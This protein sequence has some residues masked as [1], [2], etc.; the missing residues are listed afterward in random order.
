MATRFAGSRSLDERRRRRLASEFVDVAPTSPVHDDGPGDASTPIAPIVHTDEFVAPFPLE[1]VIPRAWWMH[2]VIALL[3]IS[4]GGLTIVAGWNAGPIREACGPAIGNLV[5]FETGKLVLLFSAASLFFA[6][7]LALS[8]W[9]VRSRSASDFSGRYRIWVWAAVFAFGASLVVVGDLH[10]V[11]TATLMWN[12]PMGFWQQETLLWLAPAVGIASALIWEI[13]NELRDCRTSFGVFLLAILA[14]AASISLQ[15]GDGLELPQ[16]VAATVIAGAAMLGHFALMMSLLIHARHVIHVTAEPP[17]ERLS[18]IGR[19]W[20]R[21]A[22]KLRIRLRLPRRKK[23]VS[24]PVAKPTVVET[25]EEVAAP[26]EAPPTQRKARK[27]PAEP[28]V[29]VE[30]EVVAKKEIVVAKPKI[31]SK[32]EVAK[33][34]SGTVPAEESAAGEPILRVDEPIDPSELK[35]LS[36]KARRKLRKDRREQQRV[37]ASG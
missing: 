15:L 37:E 33:P 26:P 21:G 24:Q 4:L 14:W 29:V 6:G 25:N 28:K 22:P 10:H 19:V 7:Q 16:R 23:R 2:A 11:W 27:R 31:A 17:R 13:K 30:K 34:A 3:G 9:W 5:E 1:R 8:V 32:K 36:K 20:K 12:W 35:G 18:L